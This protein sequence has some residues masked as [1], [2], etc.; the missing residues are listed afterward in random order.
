[1]ELKKHSYTITDKMR[2]LPA[3]KEAKLFYLSNCEM[4]DD[5]IK[6]QQDNGIDSPKIKL[7]DIYNYIYR[8]NSE[9]IQRDMISIVEE[10]REIGL[11]DED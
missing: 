8:E 10:L 3:T 5:Y 11:L 7:N 9:L 4:Q 6:E 1:M 2:S